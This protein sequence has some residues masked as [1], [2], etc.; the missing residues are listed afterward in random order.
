MTLT[1]VIDMGDDEE[2]FSGTEEEA[3]QENAGS[4]VCDGCEQGDGE[5]L[6]TLCSVVQELVDS[7]DMHDWKFSLFYEPD[8]ESDT[9]AEVSYSIHKEATITVYKYRPFYVRDDLMHELMHC[10]VGISKKNYELVIAYQQKMIDELVQ[11]GDEQLVDDLSRMVS[12]YERSVRVHVGE[13]KQLE[14][15]PDDSGKKDDG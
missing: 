6:T 8:D 11:N 4:A 5:V 10:K 7:L 12:R 13:P 1:G 15:F 9:I 3:E 14:L 2:K